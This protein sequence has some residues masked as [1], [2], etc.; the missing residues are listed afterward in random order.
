[1]SDD[2]HTF[3]FIIVGGGT[4]GPTLARRLAEA[5]ISGKKLKVLL[6]ESGPTSEGVEDIRCPGNW[7]NNIHS[8]HD[9]SYEVDEPYLS[10]EGEER[11]ICGIPRGH[12]L[13]GSSCLNT[14]F[15]IRGTR[16]DF[17]RI[18]EETGAKGW[19]WDDLFPYFRKHECYVPQGPAHEPKLIDFETYDY[20][21]FHGD[22]GPI[23]VQPYDYAPISKKFSESLS[24]F[25][26]PYNPEIFVNGGA[27]QGWGHV[28]RSTSNGIRSTGYDALV[29]A[30]KNLNVV[31]GHAVTKILFEEIGGKQTAVGVETYNRAAEEAGPTYKARY[32]VV[33]CCGSYAS[34]QLLMVSGVGPRKELEEVGVKDIVLDSPYVGKN[35]Q[36]HLICGIFVEIK[37]PGYTRDHQFFDDEGLEKSTEEWKSKRTG[38]FS[39]PPQ[40][41]FS[42]GRID[43]LLKDDPVWKAACEKQ[44]AINPRRDPMGNDPS[45][46]HFEI[47]NAELYIELEMTQA[48]DEGESVMTVIGEILPPR[49]KGYVKLLSPNPL[50]NPEIVHNYL[51]D[52]LDARVFAAIM[53]HAADVATNG[54]GT[55]DLVKARWPPES[56]PFEEMSIEEWETYVRDKS[57]TCFHPCGTVKLG[58][59]ND[60]EAVVDERLRVKGVDGLRVADVSVLPRVPNGHTQ[61]FAYAVGEKAADLILADIMGQD[62]RPRI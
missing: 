1:M 33:I 40:G 60:K 6:L 51:Q 37:E 21:K 39:N 19:G 2:K 34:P 3:D 15:V 50:E 52:P 32:E 18:E 7:V 25:G 23:K 14:S 48:P 53:K 28:I 61:A 26:Y 31:T 12:C 41:I 47:W 10:T 54:A 20:K 16:G 27:P 29:H 59:A 38:F 30:P 57:H 46:P 62:L 22:S 4:A 13:G 9:W 36:D 56:K 5:W 8:E 11:R 55:K 42:Y 43:N 24:S 17:D 45:Q 44:K 58:G 35:L 49:S